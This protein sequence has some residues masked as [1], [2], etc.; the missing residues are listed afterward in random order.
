MALFHVLNK[1]LQWRRSAGRPGGYKAL[2]AHKPIVAI[3]PEHPLEEDDLK[4]DFFR[5]YEVC[6]GS[7]KL[8]NS[9]SKTVSM[10]FIM[11]TKRTPIYHQL[12]PGRFYLT[13]RTTSVPT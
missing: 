12:S 5:K 1:E 6:S 10:A 3:G 13:K 2:E 9:R 11:S 7:M 4:A 8:A